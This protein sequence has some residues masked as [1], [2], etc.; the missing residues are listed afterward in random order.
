MFRSSLFCAFAAAILAAASASAQEPASANRL[1]DPFNPPFSFTPPKTPLFR[2]PRWSLQFNPGPFAAKYLGYADAA[3][4]EPRD[5]PFNE[6][7]EL[8]DD[9]PNTKAFW[10]AT[11]DL[12]LSVSYRLNNRNE[13][14]LGFSPMARG[15]FTPRDGGT[16]ALLFL[17][18]RRNR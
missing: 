9:G 5:G 6:R 13:I 15:R 3:P 1:F 10:N 17:Q 14:M 16:P 11:G 2:A 8:L 18:F 12:D 7:G 4:T